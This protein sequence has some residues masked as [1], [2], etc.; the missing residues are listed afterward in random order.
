M[1]R[2]GKFHCLT[3]I[4]VAILYFAVPQSFRYPLDL[5][6]TFIHEGGHAL[7]ALLSGGKVLNLV[8]DPNQAGVTTTMRGFRPLVISGGYLGVSLAGA[9]L[10]RLNTIPRIRKYILEAIALG[11]LAL[12]MLYA[13]NPFTLFL[14]IA[15]A[16]TLGFIGLKT[17]AFTEYLVVNFLAVYIGLGALKE[18]PT[19]WALHGGAA[20]ISAGGAAG[21]TD[22][23]AMAQLSGIPA[24]GWVV[25]WLSLSV[26]LLG[27][28]LLRG[29]RVP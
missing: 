18:F 4:L 1:S 7:A 24:N 12:T 16:G 2:S 9:L 14:G 19:L 10:L 25:L 17:S 27:R 29:A 20:R 6:L 23:E 11:V 28:E 26:F 8:V 13:G 21:M 5:F 3:L 15:T 22:A